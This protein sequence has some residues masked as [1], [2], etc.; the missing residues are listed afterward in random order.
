MP[1]KHTITRIVIISFLI[2]V[3]FALAKAFYL[4]SFMGIVLGMVSFCAGIYS[5]HILSTAKKELEREE[6]V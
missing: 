3:G 4:G 2:V 1:S 5:L 6:A